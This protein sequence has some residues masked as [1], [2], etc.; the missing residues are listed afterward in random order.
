MNEECIQKYVDDKPTVV[1]G[2]IDCWPKSQNL[3]ENMEEEK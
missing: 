2:C 1:C 3:E